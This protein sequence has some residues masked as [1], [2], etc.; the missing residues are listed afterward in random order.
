MSAFFW[1]VRKDLAR[2]FADRQGAM[3]AIAV[4]VVLAAFLGML[5]APRASSGS[6]DLLVVDEDQTPA[7]RALIDAVKADDTFV[8]EEL[9]MEEARARLSAGDADVALHIPKGTG[10]KLKPTAM[11]TGQVGTL[12]LLHDPSDKTEAD[13]AEGLLTK[14]TM[15]HTMSALGDRT[16]MGGMFDELSA[17]LPAD[18]DPALRSFL[19]SGKGLAST[20]ATPD[21]NGGGGMTEPVRFTRTE[22]S[23]AGPAAG[24]NSYSHNFAG[25]LLLFLLFGAQS[26]ARNVLAEREEGALLRVRL[27]PI[28]PWQALVATGVGRAVVALI[29]SAAVY[30][31]GMVGFG[32]RVE[33]SV[34]GFLLVVLA[35][36]AFVGG[37]ALLLAGLGRSEAQISSIGTFVV[38]VMSFAGGAMFPSFM[39]PGWLQTAGQLLPTFWAT[40]GLAAMTWRGLPLVDALPPVAV[41]LAFALGFGA[42][43][44]RRFRW[45]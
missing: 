16:A 37:F 33:G 45:G 22:V 10:E 9:S 23:A 28:P 39:M 35:Q 17:G 31:V 34:V 1:I 43:G 42:I 41:L 38:L 29:V 20:P 13:I 32:V 40:R 30:A 15:Q 36:A 6:V 25:T 27:A 5:F 44:V 7:T 26:T 12:E 8:V 24:Y 4:P 2:F 3:S 18:A 11:F 19:E 21:D 14:I